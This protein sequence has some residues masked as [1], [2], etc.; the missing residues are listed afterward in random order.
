MNADY[1]DQ[2][3]QELTAKDAEV[4][5]KTG[6]FKG[7]RK[8]AAAVRKSK[9]RD[10]EESPELPRSPRLEKQDVSKTQKSVKNAVRI[11]Q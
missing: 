10:E 6:S 1:T 2:K 4:S 9:A 11:Q 7:L 5:K 8:P 3:Q